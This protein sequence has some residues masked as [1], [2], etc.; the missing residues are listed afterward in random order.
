MSDQGASQGGA[1]D[2]LLGEAKAPAKRPSGRDRRERK[3]RHA[4][5]DHYN[6]GPPT[7]L[8][9][10]HWQIIKMHL[11]G[12]RSHQIAQEVNCT[13][14]TVW[15]TLRHEEAQRLKREMQE[16]IEDELHAQFP[17]TVDAVG[18]ALEA[19]DHKTRLQAVDRWVSLVKARSP[20]APSTQ[21][22][23]DGTVIVNARQKLA[24]SLAG[25]VDD[26]GVVDVEAEDGD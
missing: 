13:Q 23:I 8:R 1:F 10:Y 5:D 16:A 14:Q 6:N 25:L 26:E 2:D 11:A 12:Y 9:P 17:R 7:D 24:R 20:E 22:N 4:Q 19:P 15:R 3:P 21:I 18:E